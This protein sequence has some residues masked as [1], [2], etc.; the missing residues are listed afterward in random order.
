[1]WT[2]V[3]PCALV[4]SVEAA[5]A[6]ACAEEEECHAMFWADDDN[7]DDDG[8]SDGGDCSD[9]T[10]HRGVSS[11]ALMLAL[12]AHGAE[13]APTEWL[14]LLRPVVGRCRL[15][16]SKPVSKPV[17]KAPLVSVLEATMRCNAFRHCFQYQLVPL[18][19]GRRPRQL[20]GQRCA[21][22]GSGHPRW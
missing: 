20:R 5:A 9:G 12:R 13:L 2:S 14:A 22:R 4:E 10:G 1:M 6:E 11:E 21:G 7:D 18:H 16:V 19:R 3:S 15:A 8:D 17:S